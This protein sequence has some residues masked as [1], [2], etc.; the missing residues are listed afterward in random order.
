MELLEALQQKDAY[1]YTLH[2]NIDTSTSSGASF[3]ETVR[4]LLDFQSDVISQKRSKDCMRRRKKAIR[5][6]ARGDPTRT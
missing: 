6:D 5:P 1:L 3:K 4:H 2:E